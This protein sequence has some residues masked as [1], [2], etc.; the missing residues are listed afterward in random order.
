MF[1]RFIFFHHIEDAIPL[2]SGFIVSKVSQQSSMV[3]YLFFFWILLTFYVSLWFSAVLLWCARC[4]WLCVYLALESQ[5]FLNLWF[6]VSSVLGNSWLL[7]LLVLPHSLSFFWEA[8]YI[9]VS[10]SHSVTHVSNACFCI[11]SILSFCASICIFSI[12]LSPVH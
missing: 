8:N 2:S 10:P 9:Y 12:D 1:N 3:M 11:F 7:S 6:D 5:C 4:G